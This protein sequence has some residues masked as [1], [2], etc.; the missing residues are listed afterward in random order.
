MKSAYWIVPLAGSAL[1]V[2]A[3]VVALWMIGSASGERDR[4]SSLEIAPQEADVYVAL[5]TDPTSPQWL[6]VQDS[7]DDINASDSIREFID[8]ALAEFQLSWE[9]DIL[10]VAGDEAYFS[11]P[12][13]T[14]VEERKGWVAGVRLANTE[15]A[16]AV[17]EVVRREAEES[18]EEPLASKSYEGATIYFE[19]TVSFLGD[20]SCDAS[21][22]CT[23]PEDTVEEGVALAFVEDVLAIGATPDEVESVIDVVQGRAPSAEENERLQDF[24]RYQTEEFLV[25]G[26]ADLAE[27]WDLA[28]EKLP[29]TLDTS[30]PNCTE[31]EP[32]LHACVGK[33]PSQIP[34]LTPVSD[35]IEF[36]ADTEVTD[37]EFSW[38]LNETLED[39]ARLGL[40]HLEMD[41]ENRVHARL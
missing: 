11:V 31:I 33:V 7:L 41:D 29:T 38:R 35:Y 9:E 6:A 20:N 15:D 23:E 28:E 26:Y 3:A 36:D 4:F 32:G 27:V 25:W 24:R 30:G 10:P 2:A 8:E 22:E 39:T 18:G 12:D 37:L 13:I 40:L 34:D 14:E 17:F 16:R 5:N 19:K 21:G 1:I